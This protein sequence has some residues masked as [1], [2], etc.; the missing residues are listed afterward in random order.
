MQ[1]SVV[2]TA[3][4]KAPS[5]PTFNRLIKNPLQSNL[6]KH[7][8]NLSFHTDTGISPPAAVKG[9][10]STV[11]GGFLSAIE[12]VIDEEDY[13]RARAEVNRKGIDVEGYSFEGMSVGGHE[14]CVVVPQL[15]CAFDIGRC[16]PKAVQQNFLF[17]THAHLDHIG[18]LPMYLATRGLYNLKPPTVFVPP[19]IKDDVQ[20]LLDIHRSMSQVE[21][22]LDLVALEIGETYEL[23]NDLVVRPFRTHHVIPSQG[24]VIY[25]LRKKLKKQYM[26]LQGRQIEKLKKSGTQITD[27]M[28]CPEVAFTGDTASD[29]Y[30]DPKNADALRAKI[31]ITEATFLDESISV[32]HA[33][34]HGHTHL[35]EIMEHAQWIRSKA[36]VL[37]HFSPRYTL[38]DIRKGV[39]KLQSKVPAKVVAL[40]EGFKSIHS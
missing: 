15:K 31:L 5:F 36:V 4:S 12:R 40:T 30:I 38:E 34:E 22:S 25:S 29:F 1:I 39:S 16:P 18:G 7:T 13:R 19:C 32:E 20:K 26:H 24:Y 10:P 8:H 11:A 23:R 35:S 27:T 28:L 3:T 14:T 33:R 2:I 21:L 37:T 6:L 9:G 17:I